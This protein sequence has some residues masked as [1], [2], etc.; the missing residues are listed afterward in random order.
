M[1]AHMRT[2]RIRTAVVV[3]ALFALSASAL[4]AHDLFLRPAQFFVPE[5]SDVRIHVLNGT[6]TKSEGSVTRDRLRA[7]DLVS[8]AGIVGIDTSRWV[9]SGDSSMLTLRTGRAGTYVVGASLKPRELRLE[10][11]EFNNYLATDGVPDVLAARRRRGE[12]SRPARER[13]HKHVKTVLEVGG[14]YST[15]YDHVLGYPA[16]LVPLDNPYM[17][18]AGARLRVRALV[19][20]RPVANQFVLTGGRTS[21]GARI[22]Q[23]G[24]RT[25]RNG[26]VSIP[27]R[28]AG[29]WYV[30]FIHMARATSDTTIDYESKWASLTFAVR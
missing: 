16:E 9:T 18:R 20:G 15:G 21:R 26:I 29:I 5:H 27:L 2:L 8:P 4:F 24:I 6:F 7:L 10:A 23:R 25:D 1:L 11:K 22:A 17:L 28:S 30:K 12:L 3:M 19:D 13:Y 14:A